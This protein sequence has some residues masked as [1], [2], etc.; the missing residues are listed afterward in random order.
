VWF[1]DRG[2]RINVF[3]V[4]KDVRNSTL[5]PIFEARLAL[6]S[7]YPYISFNFELNPVDL[8]QKQLDNYFQN[9]PS[10]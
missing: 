1:E 2:N 5:D 3:I 9:Y 8:E 4:T 10:S 6:Y 7:Q